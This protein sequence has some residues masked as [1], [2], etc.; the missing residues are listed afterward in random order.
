LRNKELRTVQWQ[1]VNL[2]DGCITVGV[3]K[4][5]GDE[6]RV[7]LPR[8]QARVLRLPFRACI[9]LRGEE[10]YLHGRTVACDIDPAKPLG[11]WKGAFSGAMKR[12]AFVAA[13][14]T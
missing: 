3:S 2:I 1:L 6:G 8:S 5:R 10:G 9:G 11:S 12:A 4:T 7:Q 14:M 13:G